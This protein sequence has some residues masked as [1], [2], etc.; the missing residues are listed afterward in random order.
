MLLWLLH[1]AVIL[2]IA[3]GFWRTQN[4]VRIGELC[5]KRDAAVYTLPDSKSYTFAVLSRGTIVL[6]QG[7]KSY[8]WVFVQFDTGYGWVEEKYL[9]FC[10]PINA[11]ERR[12]G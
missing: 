8:T 1:I 11:V 5:T 4:T 7:A 3:Y 6:W 2:S 9:D 12:E 10:Q